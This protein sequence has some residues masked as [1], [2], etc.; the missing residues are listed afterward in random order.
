ML[1]MRGARA[2]AARARS[3]ASTANRSTR[4]CSKRGISFHRLEWTRRQSAAPRRAPSGAAVLGTIAAPVDDAVFAAW[5]SEQPVLGARRAGDV[6]GFEI[7]ARYFQFVRSGDARPL[8]A[9]ARAQPARPAVAGRADGASARPCSPRAR[10][11]R[12]TRAKRWRSAASTCAP[13]LDAT[14]A[15]TRSNARSSHGASSGD[16]PDRGAA[17]RWRC[18]RAPRA[19]SLRRGGGDAGASC[20]RFPAARRT[21]RAKRARRSPSITSIASAI[22]PRRRR[23]RCGVW[24][25]E[26]GRAGATRVQHRLARISA[27]W[28]A[29]PRLTGLD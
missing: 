26:H 24:T 18:R 8:V 15:A 2:R 4:R 14:R 11:P 13:G 5:R 27:D 1:Q 9:R 10:R 19:A 7:P 28:N 21:W 29:Q 23:L 6:P 22:W 16:D 25:P 12:A 3:S 17:R 20:S